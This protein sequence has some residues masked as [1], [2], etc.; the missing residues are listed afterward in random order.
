MKAALDSTKPWPNFGV[1]E[2]QARE[3]KQGYYATIS[4]VDA[5]IGRVLDAMDRLQLWDN[6]IVVFWSDHG[7][8]L[9]KHGL[10][11][12]RSLFEESA[13][14]PMVIVAPGAKSR[15]KAS[16][17]TV[18]LV[19]LYP[20]LADLAGLT[21]PKNLA[22]KSLKP[23][24][25]DPKAKWEKPAFTQVWRGEYSGHSIRNE[26]H[27]YIE[28]DHGDE[29]AQLYDYEKDPTEER[30]LVNDPKYAKTVTEL[31]AQLRGNWTKEFRP[32]VEE[33]KA[34]KAKK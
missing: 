25:N 14:V 6:T 11:M 3:V 17:R 1:T 31:K 26:R 12:K 5:Q 15:G 4:F 18:E 20:T 34:G 23:L 27:R 33:R 8:H 22:G 28:W 13:R 9:G 19:D 10:W 24:L 30:N 2:S 16:D 32:P 21:P 7:Y 29:G